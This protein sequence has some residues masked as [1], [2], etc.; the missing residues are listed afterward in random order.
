MRKEI[1]LIA[2]LVAAPASADAARPPN[3][4]LIVADDLGWAD[5]GCYGNRFNETPRLDQRSYWPSFGL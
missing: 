1:I 4:V 5:L 2:M 3:I